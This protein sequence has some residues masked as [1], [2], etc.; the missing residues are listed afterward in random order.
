MDK[1]ELAKITQQ[2]NEDLA[3][4]LGYRSFKEMKGSLS[5]GN[6]SGGVK[7]R[8]E[9]GGGIAESIGGGLKSNMQ[10]IKR[11]LN[12]KTVAKNFYNDLFSGPDILSSYMR[13][14]LVS[15][16]GKPKKSKEE[17]KEESKPAFTET[18]GKK[19]VGRDKKTGQFTKLTD[20][21]QLE[22][23]RKLGL[24]KITP[25]AVGGE[26]T[27]GFG[28]NI[29]G[30]VA[31]IR[32]SISAL[33]GFE[34]EK[35]EQSDS[36]SGADYFK[37]Q[38]AREAALETSPSQITV[39]GGAAPAAE[40][41]SGGGGLGIVGK[42]FGF[43]KKG[44]IKGIKFLFK[45]SR[46]L[47]VLGK[48]FILAALFV[49]LFEGITAGFDRYKETGSFTEAIT[50]G[51]GAMLDFLTF[52]LF[53]EDSLKNMFSAI[54][55]FAK[56]IIDKIG[57]IFTSIMDWVKNNIGIPLIT[58]PTP[59][60][61]QTF[62]APESLSFGP[63]YPFKDDP[64]NPNDVV[65]TPKPEPKPELTPQDKIKAEIMGSEVMQPDTNKLKGFGN[66]ADGVSHLTKGQK[67]STAS[68]I[69]GFSGDSGLGM[70]S[71]TMVGVDNSADA[72]STFGSSV[73]PTA[74]K[75]GTT[76]EEDKSAIGN[77]L[78]GGGI[79]SAMGNLSSGT[80]AVPGA[81]N[82]AGNVIAD[83]I[84]KGGVTPSEVTPFGAATSGS[85]VDSGSVE[86]DSGQRQESMGSGGSTF[87][88]P[89]TT[90]NSG[91]AGENKQPVAPVINFDFADFLTNT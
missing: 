14:R 47:K 81:M 46:L 68:L 64:S 55:D 69:P 80:A 20:E 73:A 78:Q 38:D 84:A 17:S 6:L 21:E 82:N 18:L 11:S 61:T 26:G 10:D 76:Q 25:T 9:Q 41:E 40:E 7:S 88:S 32:Q 62:G 45:P 66:T 22:K 70:N 1:N 39:E 5:K 44:L 29:A 51:L 43:L 2:R 3:K 56:P 36:K 60:W 23:Q 34:K 52:G 8:L 63:Y 90:N 28:S 15:K 49:S 13:G 24:T 48:V 30:D 75:L 27:G 59:K 4:S 89:T 71:P 16:P 67:V 91:S 86:V 35:K 57:S 42:I 74:H 54:G 37:E 53:G 58:L 83:K 72:S 33:L 77:F 85:V 12:P 31:T 87:N 65:T 50:A 19:L 79:D